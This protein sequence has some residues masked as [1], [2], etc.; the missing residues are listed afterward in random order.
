M[1]EPKE[2]MQ[3]VYLPSKMVVINYGS[4]RIEADPCSFVERKKVLN[5]LAKE[6]G[7]EINGGVKIVETP[8]EVGDLVKVSSYTKAGHANAK[9]VIEAI[10]SDFAW[11]RYRDS[12]S[13]IT[14]PLRN[15]ERR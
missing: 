1:S 3:V 12:E 4:N 2:E 13:C 14:I 6:M 11:F 8:L 10:R 9:G 7:L 5:R 15:L